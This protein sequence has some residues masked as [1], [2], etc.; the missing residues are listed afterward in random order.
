MIPSIKKLLCREKL[1]QLL[2][3]EKVLRSENGYCRDWRGIFTLSNLSLSD[4]RQV[5]SCRDKTSKLL[6][7]WS[8]S[9]KDA[10]VSRLQDCFA[11]IDR[12]D[13]YDDTFDLLSK[14]IHCTPIGD[15]YV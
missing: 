2:N 1:S 4:Y 7:L 13:I 9:Q 5:E 6:D 11:L 15:K 14:Y 8:K 12:F 10:N 3:P